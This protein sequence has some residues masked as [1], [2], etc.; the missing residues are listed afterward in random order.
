MD[1]LTVIIADDTRRRECDASC[2]EDWSSLDI[3]TL[4]CQRI[5]ER[6]GDSVQLEYLDLTRATTNRQAVEWGKKLRE[7]NLAVPLL[8]INGKSRIS[9]RFDIHQLLDAIEVEIEIRALS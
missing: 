9:G 2:G 7:K 6:F 1:K 4:A 5:R 3:L 8:I